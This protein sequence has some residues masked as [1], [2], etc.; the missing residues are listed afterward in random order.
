MLEERER[1]NGVDV[2]NAGRGRFWLPEERLEKVSGWG[3]ASSGMGYVYRPS[4][5]EG[6]RD[7]FEV[8]RQSGRSVG[9]RG[10]GNSYGDA[11][12]NDENMI[13]DLRRMKR[14]LE[15]DPLKGRI[16]LEPGVTI[17]Q[18]WQYVIEDGWWPPVVPGTSKPTIG[19]CA[20]MNIHGK[21]AWNSGTFG[22]HIHEFD[23]MLPSGHLVTCSRAENSELF[24]AAI[25]GFGMFGAF[26]SL[27]LNLRRIYSGML[28][29]KALARGNLAEMLAC[30]EELMP[31]SDY[32]VGWIDAFAGG[33]SLGRG[34]IHQ[35]QYLPPG[36]DS[37]SVQSLRLERQH[38]PDTI[39]GIL[40]N[41]VMWRLMRP[42]MNDLG[43]R[44]TNTGKYWA[45]KLTN[46]SEF[47]QPHVAFHFLLDYIPGWKRS[48]GR[49]GLIQYQSFVPAENALETYGAM[50]ALCQQHGLPS[51]LAVLKR[52][53][54][55]DFL[56]SHGVDGYSL[57]MDFR[58]TARR[59]PRLRKLAAQLDA[60][61]LAA[62][63]RFYL[64]KDSTLR[65]EVARAYLGDDV[66]AT[67]G[68]LKRRFDP[69]S[70]L[71]SNLWR[72]LFDD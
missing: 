42:F 46:D 27:T 53:R 29:V 36:A 41:S 50:L 72:R 43:A 70:L 38:I 3:G 68:D 6:I 7:V 13:L 69:D 11:T 56:I 1:T 14:I 28:D 62:G 32:L 52:H 55:D 54:P 30:F 48:Y 25:G 60:L 22:E 16:R 31:T 34:Q 5:V 8:A 12:L 44:L 24:H 64:A 37:S 35:A 40:P 10:S 66:I 71:Q 67:L 4:T 49:G 39:F 47:R 20:G 63:G 33:R 17:A 45:S 57:A 51:Y 65:P 18:L 21:N 15:W 19:G 58:V 23:F 61:V 2:D 9:L 26:T 59:R